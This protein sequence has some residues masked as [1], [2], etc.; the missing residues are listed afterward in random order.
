MG[1]NLTD[2]NPHPHPD[3]LAAH[4][5]GEVCLLLNNPS[6][7][8]YKNF[9]T[10]IISSDLPSFDAIPRIPTFFLENLDLKI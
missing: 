3:P 8:W 10:K 2:V 6:D 1:Q 5:N 4:R 9:Q 7:K